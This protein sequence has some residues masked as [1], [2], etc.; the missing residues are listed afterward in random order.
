MPNKSDSAGKLHQYFTCK[1]LEHKVP[2]S[3]CISPL[4]NLQLLNIHKGCFNSTELASLEK[5]GKLTGDRILNLVQDDITSINDIGNSSGAIGIQNTDDLVVNTQDGSKIGFSLKCWKTKSTVLSKNMGAKSLLQEYF[6]ASTEQQIFNQKMETEQ[7]DFL[8]S[9]LKTNHKSIAVA[10][11]QINNHAVQNGKSKARFSDSNYKNA[12]SQRDKFLQKLRDNL[13]NI[14]QELST[15]Q[16]ENA[17]NLILDSD[18][19][20]F[21]ASYSSGNESV[22]FISTPKIT[23]ARNIEIIKRGNDSVV[24]KINSHS[25]GFRFKFESGITSSIKL[26]GD[27]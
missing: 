20:L 19:K 21:H 13:Y 7:L 3:Q 11:K 23:G 14:L 27:Y 17:C 25:V 16:L 8:N 1:Y 12:N 26:V 10:K 5:I 4:N 2:G 22:D 24:V 18:K 15:S 6:L 9:I